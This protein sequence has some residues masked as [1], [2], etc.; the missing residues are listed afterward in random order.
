M[1]TK[2]ILNE[3]EKERPK[4][5]SWLE[6]H[7]YKIG[8]VLILIL[9]IG[10]AI[11]GLGNYKDQ[12]VDEQPTLTANSLK[13]EMNK[14]KQENSTL[15]NQVADLNQKLDEIKNALINNPAAGENNT[16]NSGK[17]AGVSVSRQPTPQSSGSQQTPGIININT[18]SASELE[19]LPG[20]GPARAE[21]IIQ[22]RN[23]NGGFKTPEEIMNISGIGE[24]TFEKMKGMI[25]VK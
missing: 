19:K 2:G 3:K 4:L 14:I 24:K 11:Y 13:E 18:A 15:K 8:F 22:Y 21:A 25:T 6:T 16:A 12:S 20:V 1:N 5:E 17:V 10:A 23:A 7:K 9:L